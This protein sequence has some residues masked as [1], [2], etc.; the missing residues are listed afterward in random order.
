MHTLRAGGRRSPPPQRA[1]APT[2]LYLRLS[3]VAVSVGVVSVGCPLRAKAF[4]Q[5]IQT[6]AQA[7]SFMEPSGVASSLVGDATATGD[8]QRLSHGQDNHRCQND[9][10]QR[11]NDKRRHTERTWRRG[12]IAVR[13]N[14]RRL[15]RSAVGCLSLDS[16]GMQSGTGGQ[17]DERLPRLYQHWR[18]AAK[19]F[20]RS[21]RSLGALG[22]PACS[23]RHPC[24][25]GAGNAAIPGGKRAGENVY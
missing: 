11:R 6:A 1:P 19:H 7:R 10:K 24:M 14:G 13:S 20:G 22:A 21:V 23:P 17:T 25:G 15:Y 9:Q 3:G 2:A 5:A 4:R 18:R 8:L 12:E 16:R